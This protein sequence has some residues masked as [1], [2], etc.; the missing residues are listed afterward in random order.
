MGDKLIEV[1]PSRNGV[2][3]G[4]GK[5]TKRGVAYITVGKLFLCLSVSPSIKWDKNSTCP[6]RFCENPIDEQISSQN[7]FG[8]MESTQKCQL[9]NYII[10]GEI[11]SFLLIPKSQDLSI[12]PF[13]LLLPALPC[14][15][16]LQM[17]NTLYT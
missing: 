4:T 10:E 3:S 9:G 5:E 7:S 6:I 2:R 12:C 11:N 8:N 14:R 16:L 17:P 1:S 13:P 15:C